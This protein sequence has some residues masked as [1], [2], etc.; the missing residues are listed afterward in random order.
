CARVR[1]LTPPF[2]ARAYRE[3]GDCRNLVAGYIL[4]VGPCPSSGCVVADAG[5]HPLGRGVRVRHT[6][7]VTR[8]VSR[9][10]AR[11]L[12]SVRALRSSVRP[13]A[14]GLSRHVEA[15]LR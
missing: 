8:A 4:S 2:L 6:D 11:A 7:F 10:R 5:A 15:P 3:T 12:P 1:N 14:I 13:V 9:T